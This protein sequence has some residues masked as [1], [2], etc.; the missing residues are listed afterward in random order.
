MIDKLKRMK[1]EPG[2]KLVEENCHNCEFNFG[3]VC[4]GHGIRKY[5]G[6]E[7]YG[8]PIEEAI[9]KFPEGC[10]HFGIS[11]NAFIKQEKMNG[12]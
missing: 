4:A 11:L 3:N 1:A 12:R 2:D 8:I 5:N 6:K 7:I 9:A 10:E